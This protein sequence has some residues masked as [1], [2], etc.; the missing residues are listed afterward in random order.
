MHIDSM[1]LQNFTVLVIGTTLQTHIQCMN[2]PASMKAKLGELSYFLL[3]TSE[4]PW[5]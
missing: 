2:I 5:C 3:G 1:Q 4:D